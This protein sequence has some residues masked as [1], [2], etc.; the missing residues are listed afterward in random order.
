MLR[1]VIGTGHYT[2][3]CRF[4]KAPWQ[5]QPI[6]RSLRAMLDDPELAPELL[7]AAPHLPE[8]LDSI[9]D[10]GKT[11]MRTL[12]ASPFFHLPIDEHRRLEDKLNE[13]SFDRG[14]AKK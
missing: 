1:G 11:T 7:E 10:T 5:E 2:A 6:G 14:V 4:E 8:L 13:L 12:R 3:E 9:G